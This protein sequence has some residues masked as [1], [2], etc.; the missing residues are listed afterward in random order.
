MNDP[1]YY[2]D[3]KLASV[4]RRCFW[5]RATSRSMKPLGQSRLAIGNQ[6]ISEGKVFAQG[7]KGACSMKC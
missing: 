1:N 5:V 4:S 7:S 2:N 6:Y 3:N